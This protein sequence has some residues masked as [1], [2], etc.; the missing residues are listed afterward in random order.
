MIFFLYKVNIVMHYAERAQSRLQHLRDCRCACG[1]W[2]SASD[3]DSCA[4]ALHCRTYC[5]IGGDRTSSGSAIGYSASVSRDESEIYAEK[6]FQHSFWV[7]GSSYWTSQQLLHETYVCNKKSLTPIWTWNQIEIWK[8]SGGSLLLNGQVS[9][10]GSGLPTSPRPADSRSWMRSE[11]PER[12]THTPT[13]L[14]SASRRGHTENF[15]L[16]ILCSN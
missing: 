15:A 5:E 7:C 14:L 2:T 12:I 3:C 16:I 6:Q 8:G 9:G 4:G 13:H 1:G 10:L 11:T